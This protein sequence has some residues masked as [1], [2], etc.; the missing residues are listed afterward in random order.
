MEP[1]SDARNSD[2][3]LV[4]I[5]QLLDERSL[6]QKKKLSYGQ[7]GLLSESPTFILG[8]W[9]SD[10]KVL[11]VH[12]RLSRPKDALTTKSL[13]KIINWISS[14]ISPKTPEIDIQMHR[15]HK[16]PL[17]GCTQRHVNIEDIRMQPLL[18]TKDSKTASSSSSSSSHTCS[19]HIYC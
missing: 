12:L 19:V 4:T 2:A 15:Q 11:S 1:F 16:T 3:F 9:P 5:C 7:L 14:E 17:T 10:S 18:Q 13:V 6:T 8:H